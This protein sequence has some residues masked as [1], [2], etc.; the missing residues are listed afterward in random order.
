MS[1]DFDLL[2]IGGGL[3]G[4]SL[5]LALQATP[6][7]I[8]LVEA[9]SDA[10][11]RASPAG[12]RALALSRSTAQSLAGLGLWDAVAARAMPIRHIHVSDRGH[13]GK[14]RLHAAEADVDALGHVLLARHLEDA[15]QSRLDETAVS[16]LCPARV[17]GLKAGPDRVFVTLKEGEETRNI[18]ARLCVAADGGNS[19]VRTL[20]GIEQRV[21]EYG[22]TAIVAEVQTERPTR[23]TAYERFT[24]TGPLAFLPLAAHRSSVVWTLADEEAADMLQRG[25]AEF[26]AS[27]QEAFGHWLGGLS[28]VSRPQGFPLRLIQAGRMDDDRVILI[29]NAMH[30]LHP[31]AGQGFN[32]GLRDAAMLAEHLEIQTRLGA[33]IGAADFLARYAATRRRD[34]ERVVRFTDSLVRLFSNDGTPLALLRNL[35]LLTLDHLPFAKRMLC[36][37]AMG[38][39][40][41]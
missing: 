5:A 34:L 13:F 35:G 2:I 4:G 38:Y 6:L 27:L 12:D 39:G 17:M 28:L 41:R 20:L 24:V 10:E 11:R 23:H 21:Q 37:H 29:G 9:L 15:I 8:G 36:R 18:S 26:I 16:R 7:R 32:L 1:M 14:T 3:V 33:D 22:Q 40:V 31:V 19:T 25:D 30:Q